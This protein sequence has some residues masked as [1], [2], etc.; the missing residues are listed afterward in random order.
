MASILYVL[1]GIVLIIM[2]A[3][4]IF[5]VIENPTFRPQH[6]VI[7]KVPQPSGQC[8]INTSTNPYR[9]LCEASDPTNLTSRYT[10]IVDRESG[11]LGTEEEILNKNFP[12]PSFT[13]NFTLPV[14]YSY[15]YEILSYWGDNSTSL[16]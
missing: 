1:A 7:Y 8:T 15:S 13:Y 14:N 9:V 10:L 12:G 11:V 6:P 2:I 3:Y 16:K 4:A 5:W